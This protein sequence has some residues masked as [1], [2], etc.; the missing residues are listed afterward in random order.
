MNDKIPRRPKYLSLS[1]AGQLGLTTKFDA[2][3]DHN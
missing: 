1:T 3:I 2:Y